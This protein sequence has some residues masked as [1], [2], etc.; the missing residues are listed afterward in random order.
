MEAVLAAMRR[1]PSEPVVQENSCGALANLA[2][3]R[4]PLERMLDEGVVEE[5]VSAIHYHAEEPN[6]MQNA[7]GCL[8]KAEGALFILTLPF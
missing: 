1:F 2:S 4:A 3:S 6:V 5:V 8:G 7:C